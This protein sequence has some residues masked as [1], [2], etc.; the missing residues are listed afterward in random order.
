MSTHLNPSEFRKDVYGIIKQVSAT[1]EPVQIETRQGEVLQLTRV[2][3]G[4]RFANIVPMPSLMTVDAED[5]VGIDWSA[6][7][8]AD[9]AVAP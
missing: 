5:F 1:G 4:S 6:G 3:K 8:D 9:A 2:R 7:W